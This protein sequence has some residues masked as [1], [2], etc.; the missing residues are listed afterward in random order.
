MAWTHTQSKTSVNTSAQEKT[1]VIKTETEIQTD[2]PYKLQQREIISFP[3]SLS[4]LWAKI[5][6]FFCSVGRCEDYMKNACEKLLLLMT[7][8][9]GGNTNIKKS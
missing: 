5:C 3:Y 2:W 8:L 1:K 7:I 4:G 6:L 9:I